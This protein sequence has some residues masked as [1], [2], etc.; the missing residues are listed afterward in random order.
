VIRTLIVDDEPVARAGLRAMLAADSEI[1]VIGECGD[2]LAAVAAIEELHPDLVL[3]DVQMPELDG[4]G[5]LRSLPRDQRPAIVFVTAFDRYAIEAFDQNAVDYLLKPFGD[6][7]ALEAV[8]R[9][10]RHIEG[11]RALQ[12]SQL[13][14][15]LR[16]AAPLERLAIRERA[17]TILVEVADIRW[18]E[19]E[20][21]Y[22]RLHA[23]SGT[24]LMR[25]SLRDLLEQLDPNMFARAS[26]SALV[27]L[28]RVRELRSAGHGD[29]IAVLDD[30]AEVKVSRN[31]RIVRTERNR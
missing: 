19:A 26:R 28:R 20:G 23:A 12:Q 29:Q 31:Y 9:A 27:N 13:D 18:I 2:G 14:G 16:S 5:V 15:V 11:G 25:A 21:D 1:E 4:F 30:G 24:H 17:R 3:L 6:T 22:A 7:R 10:K 8:A